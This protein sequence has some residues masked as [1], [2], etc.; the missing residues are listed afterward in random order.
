MNETTI[1]T[2][3]LCV[4]FCREAFF[5]RYSLVCYYS[6]GEKKNLSYQQLSELPVISATGLWAYWEG[7]NPSTR[8]FVLTA[9]GDEGDVV[10]HLRKFTQQ[11]VSLDTLDDY[12][13]RLQQR[14]VASLAINMLG[15]SGKYSY[16]KTKNYCNGTLIVD[17][18]A[19][20]HIS[21]PKKEW[22]MLKM[23]VN[24]FLCLTAKTVTFTHPQKINPNDWLFVAS[25]DVDGKH[26]QG[27]TF[28]PVV[29]S[30]KLSPN[31][32]FVLGKVGW[33]K[34]K[35]NT[36][37]FWIYDPEKR[38]SGKLYALHQVVEEV[39]EAFK[40]CVQLSFS[41]VKVWQAHKCLTKKKAEPLIQRYFAGRS[42]MIENKMADADS[43]VKEVKTLLQQ[44]AGDGLLF[45]KK[46]TG[47]H[48]V[49]KL[50][51]P[52]EVDTGTYAKSLDRLSFGGNALQHVTFAEGDTFDKNEARRILLELIVKDSLVSQTMPKELVAPVAGWTFVRYKCDMGMARGSWMKVDENGTIALEDFG[53]AQDIAPLFETFV[54]ER[55]HY[56]SPEKI[57]GSRDYMAMEKAGNVY[58]IIDT[59]ETPM[60]DVEAIERFYELGEPVSRFKNVDNADKYLQGCVN[61]HLWKT[62]DLDGNPDGAFAY[63]SGT[64]RENLQIMLSNKMSRVPHARRLFILHRERPEAVEAQIAE[65]VEMMKFGFG[66][67]NEM[68]TY[69]YPFKF[70]KEHLDDVCLTSFNVHWDKVTTRK[71]Q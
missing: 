33:N 1:T 43:F 57:G 61:F 9:K 32:V 34:D 8:F 54:R 6:D 22:A 40:G 48:M 50:C 26:F 69:P 46:P 4:D 51:L 31:D 55:L 42:V 11:R 68:M 60:L 20:F 21:N 23:E 17:D 66:R 10:D 25:G 70:L 41:K 18:D 63:F 39:N 12:P 45:P 24:P 49:V 44:E 47:R 5:E 27:R 15:I 59:D 64:N 52:E 19:R 29:Y 58:L 56:P 35:K 28:V 30:D 65:V 2:N 7:G 37:P 38:R 13:D 16:Q 36:V 3:R 53:L 14:I 71:K 62:E 67:W